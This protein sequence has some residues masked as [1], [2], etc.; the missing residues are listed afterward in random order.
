MRLDAD[1]LRKLPF[2]L[3]VEIEENAQHSIGRRAENIDWAVFGDAAPIMSALG[4]FARAV[5]ADSGLLSRI[6]TNIATKASPEL[7][8]EIGRALDQLRELDAAIEK[9]RPDYKVVSTPDGRDQIDDSGDR[10][11]TKKVQS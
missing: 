10:P 6:A 7:A 11:S 9:Y 8:A 5:S 1:I 4:R 3:C 2:A